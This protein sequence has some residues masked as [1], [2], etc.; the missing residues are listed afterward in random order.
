MANIFSG[1]SSLATLDVSNWDTSMVINMNNMF[2][3]CS[4]LTTLDLSSWD[5]SMV[6]S[7]AYMF[8]YC[9]NLQTLD[10]SNWDTSMVTDMSGM[11]TDC[12]KL[13]TLKWS[14]WLNSVVLSSTKLT[15]ESL[16]GLI[17]ELGDVTDQ[18]LTLNTTLS[19]YLNDSDFVYADTRGW[20]ITPGG[21]ISYV[22]IKASDNISGVNDST[23][24]KCAVEITNSNRKSRLD[25]VVN[26]YTACD[27]MFLYSD[28]SLVTLKSFI[29]DVDNNLTGTKIKNLYFMLN[30]NTS[31]VSDMSIML[32]NCPNLETLDVSNFD[33]S[34]VV[35]MESMFNACSKLTTI[36]VSNFN[37]SKVGVM[38]DMF[39]NC[40]KLTSLDVSNWDTSKVSDMSN[41]F[42]N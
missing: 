7:M 42:F 8:V 39:R 40:H 29:T 30:F 35:T 2:N 19:G 21:T 27:T 28:D 24:T 18:T 41:I 11:F 23:Y 14:N 20:T 16:N 22:N 15:K 3:K 37:T 9:I 4:S 12:S 25:E 10:L 38:K 32:Y 13:T 17:K 36:D 1:C 33:T 26:A 34:K 31:N 5:V 6:K